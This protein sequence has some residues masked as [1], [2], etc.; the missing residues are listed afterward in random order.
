MPTACSDATVT[1]IQIAVAV[2]LLGLALGISVFAI[3]CSPGF[4]ILPRDGAPWIA[5]P[6]KIGADAVAVDRREL[7]AFEFE[8]EFDVTDVRGPLRLRLR[9]LR[10]YELELNGELVASRAPHEG[11]WKR[12][13]ELTVTEGLL[14]GANQLRVTVRN[15][16]GPSL[17]Q[18]SAEAPGIVLESDQTWRV[19]Q[20]GGP[21]YSARIAD[22]RQRGSLGL[23]ARRPLDQILERRDALAAVATLCA[24]LSLLARW[25]SERRESPYVR[26]LPVLAWA[27]VGIVWVALFRNSLGLPPQMGFDGPD[28]LAYI[29]YVS[30][31]G[32][33]PLASDGPAMYHPPLFYVLAAALSTLLKS[34]SERL[35]VAILPFACG[36]TQIAVAHLW[37]RRLF[38]GDRAKVAVAIVAAGLTPL[39][40]YMATY[41]S[42]E[43]LNAALAASTLLL[44]TALLLQPGLPLAR[45]ALLGGVLGLAL[46]SK[47]TSLLL[48]P[49]VA[50]CLAWKSI[51]ADRSSIAG[52]LGRVVVPLGGAALL[53]GWFYLR[54][55]LELGRPFIGNWDVPGAHITW[56]QHPGFHTLD[57]YLRFGEVLWRP[58]FS[59]F[60]SLADGL[61]G[62]FWGDALAGGLASVAHRHPLWSYDY[63]SIGYLLAL[64]ATGVVVFGLASLLRKSFCATDF[65]R[66]AAW[67]LPPA[68]VLVY[69]FAVFLMTLRLPFYAQAKSAYALSLIAPLSVAAAHGFCEIQRWLSARGWQWLLV[70]FHSW[71]GTLAVVIVLAFAA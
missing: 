32:V 63:M 69:L 16:E 19:S 4:P 13:R 18:L 60:R 38:P 58:F 12:A 22:D 33:L 14:P 67:A 55:W 24:V 34:G 36:L 7:R 11:N 1:R 47:L 53:S 40:L 51:L 68:A 27:G 21:V 61:Y 44:T 8:R 29:H 26:G 31:Q 54:N 71:A 28:H 50:G 20:R 57:Y 56:W 25:L 43:P 64:P 65:G 66:R 49:L 17:L 35:A 15:P 3:R 48:V 52:A 30:E 41:V 42:N 9:A 5:L 6:V 62:T 39:N 70:L 46:L 2:S 10:G 59:G 45:L 23:A 37:A